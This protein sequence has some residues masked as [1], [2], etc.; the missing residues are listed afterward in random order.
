[1][2]SKAVK[3]LLNKYN[4]TV[5]KPFRVA[6]GSFTRSYVLLCKD[7]DGVKKVIKVFA[8][9][10]EN[11]R[12]RFFKE[13]DILKYLRKNPRIRNFAIKVFE[14][15]LVSENPYYIMEYVEYTSFGEF[16]KDLG[17]K[18]G[19]FKRDSFQKFLNFWSDLSRD[20]PESGVSRIEHLNSYGY[21]RV[22]QELSYYRNN[23]NNILPLQTWQ[24]VENYLLSH[25]KVLN[26]T[27]YFSHHDLYPENIFVKEPFSMNFKVIDWEQSHKTSYGC[28]EAFLYL[29]FFREDYFKKKIYARVYSQTGKWPSF[30]CFLLAFS[31]RFLYQLETFVDKNHS[32]YNNYRKFL[33]SIINDVLSG[34]FDRPRN[35]QFLLTK[36]IIKTILSE[37]YNTREDFIFKDFAPGFGNTMAKIVT[38][39]NN[40]NRRTLVLRVYSPNRLLKNIQVEARAYRLLYKK[41]F[42]TY[43]VHKN[44]L[45]K[46]VSK[47]TLYG[48]ERYGILTN[49]IEG[50]TISRKQLNHS[51]IRRAGRWL[52]KIHKEKIIHNDYNRRNVL[53]RG[54]RISGILDMEFCRFTKNSVDHKRDLA[55]A[56]ALWMQGIDKES[57]L[58]V[59]EVY[60]SFMTG[61]FGKNWKEH[62]NDINTLLVEELKRLKKDYA[63]MNRNSPS[64][65][66]RNIMAYIDTLIG[67]FEL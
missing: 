14:S 33:L 16:T 10:D 13:I 44:K 63:K 47:A 4:L 28:N 64:Q 66:F 53:Y 34:K 11:A 41:G 3:Q 25:K 37:H 62:Q 5:V 32:S 18:T 27:S 1:M 23:S 54:G 21:N 17:Y 29:M 30:K 35:L 12:S 40:G 36:E 59:D 22:E 56:L 58:S 43:C 31:I 48:R 20:T 57:K 7:K 67:K 65:Y 24:E 45:G 2:Y 8:S 15:G 49:Y 50:R 61:Y 52:N 6:D 60:E 51:H 42:P 19:I 38:M 26:E 9:T 55:K 39:S 46:L